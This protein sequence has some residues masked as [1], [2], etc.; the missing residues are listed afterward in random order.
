M[1]STKWDTERHLVQQNN[2]AQEKSGLQS[3]ED[4]IYV[5]TVIKT[6]KL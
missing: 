3:Q 5:V 6:G 2:S 4:T 1:L